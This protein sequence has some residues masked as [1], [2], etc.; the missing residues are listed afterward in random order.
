M[1]QLK[2]EKPPKDK[3]NRIKAFKNRLSLTYPVFLGGGATVEE[4][5][6][7]FHQLNGVF[8]FPTTLFLDKKGRIIEVHSGFDGPATGVHYE[9]LKQKTEGLLLKLMLE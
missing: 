4:A 5:S 8:S 7:I 6:R 1:C 9:A 3:I 2:T